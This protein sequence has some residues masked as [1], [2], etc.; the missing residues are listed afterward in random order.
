M[1][2]NFTEVDKAVSLFSAVPKKYNCAQSVAMA[3][4]RD[5]LV[6][7]LK[8]CG[9]GRAEGGLCGALHATLLLLP[10]NKWETVKKQ[11]HD[12]AGNTL[13]R[14]IRREGNTPCVDCVRIAVNLV[15]ELRNQP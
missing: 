12:R 5:D 14:I 11:F 3:F 4:G 8:T 1:T 10:E 13:C 15:T 7:P 2:T 9:G 6:A